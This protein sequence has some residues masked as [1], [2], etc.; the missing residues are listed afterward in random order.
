ML[1]FPFKPIRYCRRCHTELVKDIL[2][3]TVHRQ[4][5]SCECPTKKKGGVPK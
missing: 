4:T 3:N 5:N 2:D 1:H